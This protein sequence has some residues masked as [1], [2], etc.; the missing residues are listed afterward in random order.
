[1]LRTQL[2][3]I[4]LHTQLEKEPYERWIIE[5]DDRLFTQKVIQFGE[6]SPCDNCYETY[7]RVASAF[8]TSNTITKS[9]C[10]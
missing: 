10:P 1:M 9:T 4:N 7:V 8:D 2:N 5:M 3:P 6:I